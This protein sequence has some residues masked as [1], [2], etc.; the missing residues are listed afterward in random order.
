MSSAIHL[1]A[2]Y[3]ML[4]LLGILVL[5]GLIEFVFGYLSHSK[6]SK[7]DLLVE[8]VN[9]FFL[10]V[11]TKPV[12]TFL[13]FQLTKLLMPQA[14]NA[15]SHWPFG[16]AL[17]V[18]LLVD[19][20]LQYWY[21]RSSHEYKWLWKWHRPHH[22]ATE[23]GLLVSYRETI[24]FYMI[25][26]NVW[27]LGVFTFL[28]GEIAVAVGIVL[29]QIVVISSH[30]LATWDSFFYKNKALLPVLKILERIFITPAFHHAHHAVSK[31]DGV[32]NPNGN[33]G[34]MLSIWDQLF[35]TATFKHELPSAYGIPNDPKDS[36]AAHTFYPLITSDKAGSELSKDFV[37]EKTT[38]NE[39]SVINLIS[40]DYL[41]CTCGYSRN[42]P[43][44]DGSHHGTKF[45]PQKFTISKEREYKLCQCKQCAKGPFCD[46]SHLRVPSSKGQS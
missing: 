23:M 3:H 16:L 17:L 46:D 42:Q 19:D 9:T 25:M 1:I 24:F 27:W 37:F 40:G 39:P 11:I 45:Q 18:F 41:Y 6:R 30:S 14:E 15:I 43:F 7:D 21:H 38:V 2:K 31:I 29:K 10:M 28:G 5:F 33:F 44:C 8:L 20:C 32:G 4:F 13:A 22:A 34:N 36:W 12:V 35:G 26:P